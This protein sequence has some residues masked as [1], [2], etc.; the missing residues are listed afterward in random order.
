MFEVFLITILAHQFG[1]VRAERL[2]A[3]CNAFGSGRGPGAGRS[4]RSVVLWD[5]SDSLP[6]C[7]RVIDDEGRLPRDDR[8]WRQ[9]EPS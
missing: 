7:V 5:W 2:R 6:H 4:D 3:G 9:P 1:I 8:S